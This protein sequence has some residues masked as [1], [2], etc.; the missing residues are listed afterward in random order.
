MKLSYREVQRDSLT[1]ASHRCH[2]GRLL[3]DLVSGIVSLAALVLSSGILPDRERLMV[4]TVCLTSCTSRLRGIVSRCGFCMPRL[5][6][7]RYTY[8]VC[9]DNARVMDWQYRLISSSF[10]RARSSLN[11]HANR[12]NSSAACIRFLFLPLLLSQSTS[13]GR[14]SARSATASRHKSRI[15]LGTPRC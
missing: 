6:A 9:V 14:R 12:I 3:S 1:Q 7:P 11:G 4:S 2:V 15:P 5:I 13:S 8:T 10:F